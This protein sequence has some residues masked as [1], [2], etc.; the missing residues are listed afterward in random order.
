MSMFTLVISCL[1]TSKFPWFMGLTVQVPMQ[2]C[3]LQ[4]WSL[5]PSI[6]TYTTGCCFC[7]DTVSSFFLEL[8]LHWLP[9]YIGHLPT[10]G[11]H[12]SVSYPFCLTRNE[13]VII[14]NRVWIAVHGCNLKNDRMVSVHFQEK[15]CN[16]IVIQVSAPT[17]NAEETEDDWFYEDQQ[18]LL[19]LTP[20]NI[21]FSL[22]QSRGLEC[23]SR[24]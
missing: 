2:F 16:I 24:K 19:E 15:P 17:S 7:F 12:L 20:Q 5:S 18:R 8:V 3:S 9:V 10:W 22:F 4:H 21:S 23:K 6:V 1:N 13:V 14:V 11:V